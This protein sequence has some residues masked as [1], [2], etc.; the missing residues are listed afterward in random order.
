MPRKTVPLTNT[1]IKNARPKA[2]EYSLADGGGLL[3]RVKTNG[4]RLW[5]F[6]YSKPYT[7]KRANMSF[8]KF[9][10]L[11]LAEARD[12][13]A[14][15]RSLLAKDIDPKAHKHEEKVRAGFAAK[16]TLRLVAIEWLKVKRSKVSDDHADDIWRSL[17][18]N[19]FLLIG[20]VPITKITAPMTISALR[21]LE[22][23]GSLETV[24]RQCQRINEVMT[25][26]LNVGLIDQ[27]PLLGIK[28]A[29]LVPKKNNMPTL[30]PSELPALMKDLYKA[31]IK[32]ETRCLIEFQLHTMVRPSEAAGALWAEIDLN[33]KLWTIPAGRMKKKRPHKIPLTSQMIDLLNAMASRTGHRQHIFC[34]YINPRVSMN[35]QTANMALKRMGYGGKLVAHGLRSLA[36]TILNETQFPKDIIESALAHVDQN[37]TR[38]D[39][40]KAEYL[41][42]RR[43]M[44]CWWSDHIEQAVRVSSSIA[45]D[46]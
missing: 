41:E 28:E 44:M 35:S 4:S 16:S 46:L 45:L 9:P 27:N 1:E 31:S 30:S 29:F 7:K 3:L 5:I 18:K 34:G 25:F 11:S 32:F 43:E 24:K 8:G 6:N 22:A 13:G 12:L 42:P 40:N 2:R 19:T 14:K 33:A 38:R 20:D 17:E 36:S 21:P 39:Y 37:E 15:A 23:R 10:D 26:A